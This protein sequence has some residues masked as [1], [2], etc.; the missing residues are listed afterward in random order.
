[1]SIPISMSVSMSISI[2]VSV[3]VSISISVSISVSVSI[4]IAIIGA[5][6]LFRE[7]TAQ[8]SSDQSRRGGSLSQKLQIVN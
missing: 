1:M 5:L 4:S 6:R 8:A 3:S 2:S 7:T